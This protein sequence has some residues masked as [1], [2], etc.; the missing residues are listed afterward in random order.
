MEE[1][2]RLWPRVADLPT[3]PAATTVAN[4]AVVATAAAAGGG[5]SC[6]LR[7]LVVRVLCRRI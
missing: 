5:G 7:L 1:L 4:V 6:G 2:E 3:V